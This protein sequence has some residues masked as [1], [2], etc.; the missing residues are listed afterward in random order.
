MSAQK[1]LLGVLAGVAAGTLLGVLFAP[2]KGSDTRKKISK[3]AF[4]AKADLEEKFDELMTTLKD[5]MTRAVEQ[6]GNIVEKSEDITE[7]EAEKLKN[8]ISSNMN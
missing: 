3:K 1:V 7:A 4:D 6:V 8:D 5:K 2:D